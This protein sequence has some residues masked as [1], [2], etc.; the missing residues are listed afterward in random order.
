MDVIEVDEEFVRKVIKPRRSSSH[1]GQNGVVLV[2]GGSWL[3]HGAPFLSAMAALRSGVDLAYI[4][5]PEKT[6]ISIRALSPNIIVIPLTDVKL[7]RGASRRIM[8]ILST[9]DSIV[10]GPGLAEGS[11]KGIEYII[12]EALA[13]DKKIVLDATALYPDILP[14]IINRKIVVTP[15][16][17][18]FKRMF[19][20]EL[21]G[22]LSERIAKVKEKAQEYKVTVLLKGKI[23]VISNGER[24]AINKTGS[25]AMTVGGTGDVLAGI[26]AGLLAKGIEPFEAAAAGAWFNGRA[27]EEASTI[28]GLHILA[29]DL[30]DQ[31]PK[32]MKNFDI[33]V[34]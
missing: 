16:A 24:T 1:K 6:A 14:K 21:A 27:G 3:Y 28:Y 31:I 12:Q 22:E 10:I 33:V 7:T 23:D 26:V 29:S 5:T 2:V 13:L 8:K 15:H 18:E 17:G 11:S 30:L 25:P 19:G 34:D 9:V 4:A 32:I 20:V